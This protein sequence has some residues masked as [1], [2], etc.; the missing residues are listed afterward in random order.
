MR[1]FFKLTECNEW[2]GERWHFYIPFEINEEAY[3]ELWDFFESKEW[4]PYEIAEDLIPENEV[5]ILV[6]YTESGYLSFHNKLDG[7]LNMSKIKSAIS[8][9]NSKEEDCFY[10]G[11]IRDMVKC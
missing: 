5:D 1:E 9:F 6:K 10:K 11:G 3:S 8:K 4:E 2:E 7:I